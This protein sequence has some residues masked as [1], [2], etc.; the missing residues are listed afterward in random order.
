VAEEHDA[1]AECACLSETGSDSLNRGANQRLAS[2]YADFMR[3]LTPLRTLDGF[4]RAFDNGGRFWSLWSDA[5]DGVITKGELAK[6]GASLAAGR[7]AVLHFELL[8]ACLPAAEAEQALASLDQKAAARWKKH[9]PV[10]CSAADA[11]AQR[12]GTAVIVECEAVRAEDREGDGLTF[13]MMIPAGKVMVPVVVPVAQRHRLWRL[14]GRAGS[15]ATTIL[16]VSPKKLDLA[17]RRLAIGAI[18]EESSSRPSKG[19]PKRRYLVGVAAC[20]I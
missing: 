8:R 14:C 16:A 12:K 5:G 11:L 10:R 4:T 15:A 20:P 7:T 6:G 3:V 18:V 19:E 1:I 9:E 17:G 13:V 2:Q